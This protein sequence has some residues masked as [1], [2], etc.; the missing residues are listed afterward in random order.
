MPID[1]L[2][3]RIL[4]DVQA[5]ASDHR[6]NEHTWLAM[7][8]QDYGG[9]SAALRAC[10]EAWTW[11]RSRTLVAYD[12]TQGYAAGFVFITRRGLEVLDRG[13]DYLRA[14][15][16]LDVALHPALE[17]K[18]RPQ[19][20]RGDF[21]TAAFVAFKEVEVRVRERLGAADSLLG[22]PLMRQAFGKDKPLADP[23]SDPGEVVAEMEFFAGAVGL[24][25]NPTSHRVV[26]YGSATEAAEVI[27]VADLLLRLYSISTWAPGSACPHAEAMRYDQ[28]APRSATLPLPSP[29]QCPSAPRSYSSRS[30]SAPSP[31]ASISAA[32]MPP[33]EA[34][35]SVTAYRTSHPPALIADSTSSSS[36][37]T[38]WQ[39]MRATTTTGSRY[40]SASHR[41]I[42]DRSLAD[43]P[44]S[45]PRAI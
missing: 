13:A 12:P 11:L 21:E 23:D 38:S 30:I 40:D 24:F 28:C 39:G 27:L 4:A 36:I 20:L 45:Q 42:G 33:C 34:T 1:E 10:S 15:E 6:P 8:E 41:R 7:L 37:P 44:R 25:K 31:L 32:A 17:E 26:D 29:C 22:V 43:A 3:L 9:S 2:G 14:V 5:T 16:R 19:F 35:A 18:A